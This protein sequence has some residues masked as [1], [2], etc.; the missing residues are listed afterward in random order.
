MRWQDDWE[1]RN[2][3]LLARTTLEALQRSSPFVANYQA[4]FD[5][6][7]Q[8]SE[9]FN[10]LAY[11]HLTQKVILE[12]ATQGNTLI[13]GRGSQF[14]LHGAPRTLHIY[15]FAP[16]HSRIENVMRRFQVD[17]TR[18]TELIEQRDYDYDSYLRRYYGAD[19]S[20]PGLY[21]LLINTGLFSFELAANLVQQALQVAKEI[22]R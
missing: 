9:Q 16:R 13:V 2:N 12:L 15:V 7:Q 18:A 8:A 6:H 17:R 5:P 14:L 1:C 3:K 4:L 10:E 22:K 20:Q 19:G 21:H 11:L